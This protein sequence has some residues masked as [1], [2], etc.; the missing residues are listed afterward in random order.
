MSSTVGVLWLQARNDGG[1]SANLDEGIDLSLENKR[2]ITIANMKKDRLSI[3]FLLCC[4]ACTHIKQ[5]CSL[6]R[7]QSARNTLLLWNLPPSFYGLIIS[8][9]MWNNSTFTTQCNCNGG[10][11]VH[12]EML[13]R[14]VWRDGTEDN[15]WTVTGGGHEI[16]FMP[17]G[18][19][20][21]CKEQD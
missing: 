3:H 15:N 1:K 21:L 17:E 14:W 7:S 6:K 19:L 18:T 20:S 4:S 11:R 13:K 5:Q 8:K 12:R 9:Q 10:K 2:R 16:L